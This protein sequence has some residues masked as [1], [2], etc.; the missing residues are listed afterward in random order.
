MKPENNVADF[1]E[2]DVV[3]WSKALT[4]WETYVDL[5]NKNLTCLELGSR[6]GGLSLWIA[7]KGNNV[8]CSDVVNHENEARDLHKK[9]S[10]PGEIKYETIDATNIPYENHFDI[11]M[12]K[13]ILGGITREGKS[14]LLQTVI[15]QIYKSLKPGGKLLFV[16]NL[17]ASKMHKLFRKKLVRW[18]S[19]WNYLNI[20]AVE[21][22]FERFDSYHC[23]TFGFLGA[24]GMNDVQRNMLGRLD[25]L[26]FERITS[27]SMKYIVAGVATK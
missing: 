22:L 5:E 15:D 2:W 3:N 1:I 27:S 13:S 18:G 11:V 7:L 26:L 6:R 12:F 10:Y 8:I 21:K 20:Q 23:K 25:T 14:E 4:Y 17:A 24:L 16:E 19:S 9:Y